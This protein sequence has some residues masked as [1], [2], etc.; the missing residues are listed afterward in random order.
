MIWTL[1]AHNSAI[2]GIHFEGTDI[3]TRGFTGEMA[4]WKLSKVPSSQ[5]LVRMIGRMV[6]CLP[7]R[8]EEDTGGLV[9]QQQ[10]EIAIGSTPN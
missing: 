4:R 3:V 5:D 8:F 6:R 7:I 9:K 10:C 2:S 1:R